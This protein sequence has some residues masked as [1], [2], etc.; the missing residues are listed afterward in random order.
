M[1]NETLNDATALSAAPAVDDYVWIWDTSVSQLKKITVA[2]LIASY[3]TG[4]GVLATGGFTLTVPQSMTAAGRNVANTFSALQTFSSGIN[5]GNENLTVYDEGTW[6][7]TVTGSSSNP[8]ITYTSQN[9]SYVRIGKAVL[10]VFSVG[11]TTTSGGSGDI[12]ISLPHTPVSGGASPVQVA[13]VNLTTPAGVVFVPNT[14]GAYGRIQTIQD[15][16]DRVVEQIST[17]Q[18]G[19]S[20]IS[21]GVYFL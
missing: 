11:I 1:P 14:S 5:L 2:N 21:A 20:F 13:F 12:R 18:A 19:S 15:N 17:L 6:T 8:T 7:P 4:G 9:G 16:A 10:F 3:F